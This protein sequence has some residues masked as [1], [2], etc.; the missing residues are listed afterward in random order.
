LVE[1]GEGCGGV[2]DFVAEIVGDAAVG[3]DVEEILAEVFREEPGGYGEIFVVGACKVAAVGLGLFQRRCG[4]RDGVGGGEAG[5]AESGGRGWDAGISGGRRCHFSETVDHKSD[6]RC[7][8]SLRIL[9][10][11]ACLANCLK[12][13]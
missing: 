5:P 4:L 12:A 10:L 9:R 13:F 3:V 8:F 6:R 1:Q 7:G 11:R 2:A